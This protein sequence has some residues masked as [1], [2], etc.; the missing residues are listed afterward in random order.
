MREAGTEAESRWN[1]FNPPAPPYGRRAFPSMESTEP[2]ADQRFVPHSGR[3]GQ[4]ER[5]PFEEMGNVESGQAVW[6]A[7]R[8]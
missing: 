4:V 3:N 2:N 5:A 1:G 8:R 7:P 6:E